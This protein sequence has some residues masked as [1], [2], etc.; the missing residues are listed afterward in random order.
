M[1]SSVNSGRASSMRLAVIGATLVTYLALTNTRAQADNSKTLSGYY[2]AGIEALKA[3]ETAKC[4]QYV[5]L[6]RGTSGGAQSAN[7]LESQLLC[8]YGRFTEA[9]ALLNQ[10]LKSQPNSASL[11]AQRAVAYG[12]TD[13]EEQSYN[14]YIAASKCSNITSD[15]CYTIVKG[16][17]E[18]DKWD[19]A[20]AVAQT[21]LKKGAPNGALYA[22]AGDVARKLKKLDLA[23][24]YIEKALAIGPAKAS[25]FQELASLHK[26]M[27]KWP[28]VINDCKRLKQLIADPDKHLTYARCLEMSGEAHIE[29]KQYE[30]AVVDFSKAFKISPLK[31]SILKQRA[32]AYEKLGKKALAQ[33]DIA[34]AKQIDNSF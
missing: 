26:V 18:Y 27:K 28:A 19:E 15:D 34:A 24:Q 6:L 29:L 14:D 5:S 2:Q 33:K 17:S 8:K 16:L 20:L 7:V 12:Y 10:S 21:G 30:E 23:E 3:N 9:L 31:S 4:K 13:N 22:L 11:L 25:T 1:A 32:S